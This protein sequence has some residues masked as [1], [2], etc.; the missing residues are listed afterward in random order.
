MKRIKDGV[1]SN[2]A[3]L[4][5]IFIIIVVTA[6]PFLLD[7]QSLFKKYIDSNPL[8]PDNFIWYFALSHGKLVASVILFVL[9]LWRI[10]KYNQNFLMNRKNVYHNYCYIW[11]WICAKVLGIKKC[12]L[13]RVPVFMQ[14]KLVIN[15]TFEEYPLN[16]DEYPIVDDEPDCLVEKINKGMDRN[17][18]NLILED[19]YLIEFTQLPK[20]KQDLFTVKVSR[21]DGTTNGRHFSQKLIEATINEV[22]NLKSSKTINVYATTNPK[23]TAHIAKRVFALGDRGNIKQLYVFQQKNTGRRYFEDGGH[24]IY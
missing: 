22:R 16:D 4:I 9:I 5:E 17:E 6:I 12:N 19:T 10:R 24:K 21:N 13:V 2:S 3:Q 20:S 18:I 7:L 15:G 14:F 1:S 8:S 11:Y 23:N